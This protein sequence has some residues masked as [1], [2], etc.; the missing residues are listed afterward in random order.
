MQ[1]ND[2]KPLNSFGADEPEDP[3]YTHDPTSPLRFGT[4]K[5]AAP[6]DAAGPDTSSPLDFTGSDGW[7]YRLS[8]K[9]AE[10]RLPGP[11]KTLIKDEIRALGYEVAEDE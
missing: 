7:A 3:G 2:D 6:D 11:C 9:A 8:G 5:G 4:G 1:Q 10:E